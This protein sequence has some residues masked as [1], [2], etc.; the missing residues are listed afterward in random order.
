MADI[1]VGMKSEFA[2]RDRKVVVVSEGL[3]IG[4]FR[5]GDDFFAYESS[6]P[7]M[8]GPVCQGKILNRVEE[9][10]APDKTAIGLRFSP[11]IV[12]I[13]CPWHGFEFDIRTGI[14][15]GNSTVKL[16]PYKVKLVGDEV[17]VVT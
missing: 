11:E 15:Q 8:G 2:P 6:C 9:M 10:L 7:H 17:Y 5:L 3:E 14:H 1:Y 16:T 4:V 13:V 12:N